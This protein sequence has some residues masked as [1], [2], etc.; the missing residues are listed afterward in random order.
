MRKPVKLRTLTKE[1]TAEI[2]RL[3]VTLQ[4]IVERSNIIPLEHRRKH[5]NNRT[6]RTS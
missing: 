3:A 2:H 4:N 6:F 1:E 5:L